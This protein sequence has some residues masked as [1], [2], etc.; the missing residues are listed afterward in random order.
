MIHILGDTIQSVGVVI[1]SI[2]IW[3][4]PEH[5]KIADPICTF[6]FSILVIFTTKS[7]VKDCIQV[8]M[9]AAPSNIDV[10]GFRSDLLKINGVLDVHDLH[11]WC[12]SSGKPSMSAHISA[13]D[14][15][16][17]IILKNATDLCRK[18]GISHTTIQVDTTTDE[19]DAGHVDCSH[20]LH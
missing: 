14:S 9:E 3:I 16:D 11:V 19:N 12:L 20:N 7:V 10:D 17:K 5:L 2:L 1:A 15:F 13:D 6:I 18:I 4:W 8:L